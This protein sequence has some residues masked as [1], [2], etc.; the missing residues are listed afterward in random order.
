VRS[1]KPAMRLDA[2]LPPVTLAENRSV[3]FIEKKNFWALILLSSALM[4]VD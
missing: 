1:S 2:V 4:G 3:T